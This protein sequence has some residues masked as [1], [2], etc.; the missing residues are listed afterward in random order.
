M[1]LIQQITVC[2]LHYHYSVSFNH[3]SMAFL[4]SS[5]FLPSKVRLYLRALQFLYVAIVLCMQQ[6]EAE[7]RKWPFSFF[8]SFLLFF[9]FW[10]S[11]HVLG[12]LLLCKY[13]FFGW[14]PSVSKEW[15]AFHGLLL[16]C[17]GK[18]A[19][20]LALSLRLENFF[21]ITRKN[22]LIQVLTLQLDCRA[23]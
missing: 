20:F 16:I 17:W 23:H 12:F 10:G 9:F 21:F 19:V 13:N 2:Y 3:A 15:K 8:F 4:N 7:V 22:E 11:F 5:F 18:K 14:S 6:F 1:Y